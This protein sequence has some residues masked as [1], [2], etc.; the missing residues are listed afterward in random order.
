MNVRK[1]RGATAREV[2]RKVKET[3]GPDALILSNRPVADGVEI[4]AIASAEEVEF[5]PQQVRESPPPQKPVQSTPVEMAEVME[6]IRRMRSLLEEQLAGFAWSDLSRREPMKLLAMKKLLGAG[7]SPK[8]SRQMTDKMPNFPSERESLE[9]LKTAVGRNVNVANPETDIVDRGGVYA[10]VGPTG[11]GK[12][13]TTAKLAARCVVRH[14]A[15]KLALVTTDSYRIG[16]HEQL[17]IYGRILGVPVH[18]IKEAADLNLILNELKDKHLVLIDT[19][20][21]SQK[22]QKVI[23]QVAMLS[24]C[25]MDVE[26]I[27]LI[28]ATSGGDT[29]DDVVRAYRGSGLG[30]CILTKVDEAIGIGASLDVILR[31]K[32]VLHFIANGQRVPEDIHPANAKYLVERAFR[33]FRE[34]SPHAM[35]ESEY[36][37]M[38]AQGLS[39]NSLGA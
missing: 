11:V 38:M 29:L 15:D 32:M 28:N 26:R 20:G 18:A 6:E 36:S 16:A 1:F 30:G 25:E 23:D 37:M 9:W 13:T 22:D 34:D 5:I 21:M 35:Q 33:A 12:T 14:G 19:I 2:L 17:R 7:F 3:L 10:I 24:G 4:T 39:G 31:H 27:L 8:L